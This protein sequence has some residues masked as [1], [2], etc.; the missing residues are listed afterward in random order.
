MH[1]TI[2]WIPALIAAAALAGSACSGRAGASESKKDD[3]DRI[4]PGVMTVTG[5]ATLDVAPDTADVS[6]TLQTLAPR[7]KNAVVALRARQDQLV[8]ALVALGIEASDIKISQLGLAPDYIYPEEGPPRLR[9]YQASLVVTASTRRF[10]LIGDM[11]E[12][13]AGAGAQA[14]NTSF[15]CAGMP[16]LKKKVRDMA[17]AAA[18][19]KAEQ[20]TR[21]FGVKIARITALNEASAGNGWYFDPALANAVDTEAQ[22]RVTLSPELQPLSLTIT[23]GY[24]LE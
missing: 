16:E 11:M 24:E 7:P 9:G 6:M 23:V 3:G 15:R 14:M 12:A 20:M 2:R 10:E 18:R 13:G 17:I 8:A 19:D 1:R 5:T 22:R 4:Q 21:G